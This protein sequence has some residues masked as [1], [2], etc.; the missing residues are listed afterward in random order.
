MQVGGDGA[1]CLA[2]LQLF[3]KNA[4]EK[5]DESKYRFISTESTAFKTKV[6]ARRAVAT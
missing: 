3:I 6:S 2:L 5:P 1:K 4:A